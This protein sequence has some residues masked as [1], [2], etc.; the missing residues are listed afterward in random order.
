MGVVPT[1]WFVAGRASQVRGG[2]MNVLLLKIFGALGM[3]GQTSRDRAGLQETGRLTG[4][5]V[6]ADSA[7]FLRSGMLHLGIGNLLGLLLVAHPAGGLHVLLCQHDFT[8]LGRG[9]AIVAILRLKRIVLKR[10]H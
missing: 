2:L 4:M 10:L 8:V 9:M 3:A 1:M 5:R 6:M 7:I